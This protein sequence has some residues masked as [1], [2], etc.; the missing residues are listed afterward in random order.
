MTIPVERRTKR[1]QEQRWILDNIIQS[2]GVEWDQ[3]RIGYT[4]GP[5]G[6][7]AAYDFT[8]VRQRVK[9]FA[10]I[11]PQ[12]AA[13]ARRREQVAQGHEREGRVVGARE[14]YFIAALLW[15]SAQ[16]PLFENTKENIFFN[17]RKVECYQKFIAYAPHKIERVEIPFGNS[18]LPAY[19]HLPL[20]WNGEKV[21]CILSIDGMDGSKEIMHAMYGDKILSRGMASLA[22]DGPGQGECCVRTIHVTAD[23]FKEV[24]RVALDWLR[25][26]PEI[27][28]E[29]LGVYGVSFGSYFATQVAS[30]DAGLRGCAVAF[31]CHEPGGHTIFNMASPTFKLRFMYMAGYEDEAEFDRFAE[32]FRLNGAEVKSP[33]LVLAGED[34]ELSPIEYT[35]QL[36]DEIPTPKKLVVYQGERHGFGSGSAAALGPQWMNMIADWFFDRFAG[37]P[38]PSERVLVDATGQQQTTPV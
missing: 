16:W 22:I 12:F 1:W 34:D 17:E 29:Q 21:P 20:A 19:L 32:G 14:S 2:V 33:Y 10:D 36:F 9:K 26:R 28:G 24:G 31:V 3:A 38:M 13:A 25:K 11:A 6:P 4:L 27:D 15:A 7:E 23:N 35:Y 18:S 8:V 30:V 5:C 37:R